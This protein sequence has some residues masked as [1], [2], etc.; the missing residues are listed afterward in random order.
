L[1]WGETLSSDRWL[2]VGLIVLG[3]II[4]VRATPR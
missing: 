3:G 1:L 2:A 4:S